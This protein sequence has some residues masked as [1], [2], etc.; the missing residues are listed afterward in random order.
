[1]E[2][3]CHKFGDIGDFLKILVN[4]NFN[5]KPEYQ[6]TLDFIKYV[7][8]K[9]GTELMAGPINEEDRKKIS[10]YFCEKTT[11]TEMLFCM[12]HF[13]RANSDEHEFRKREMHS[14]IMTFFK[15]SEKYRRILSPDF[16][17]KIQVY[18]NCQHSPADE[19]K[20]EQRINNLIQLKDMEFFISEEEVKAAWIKIKDAL[21]QEYTS[22]LTSLKDLPRHLNEHGIEEIEFTGEKFCFLHHTVVGEIF[23]TDIH[24]TLSAQGI[25]KKLHETWT[26]DPS[27]VLDPNEYETD[28]EHYNTWSTDLLTSNNVQA[29]YLDYRHDTDE[30]VNLIFTNVPAENIMG[31]NRQGDGRE[32]IDPIWDKKMMTPFEDYKAQEENKKMVNAWTGPGETVISKS[33]IIK[34]ESGEERVDNSVPFLKPA[35]VAICGSPNKRDISIAKAFGIP[36]VKIALDKYPLKLQGKKEQTLYEKTE[37]DYSVVTNYIQEREEEKRNEKD[38]TIKQEEQSEK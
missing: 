13:L 29:L 26:K 11:A 36:F 23:K 10:K 8:Q 31:N 33:K 20:V 22:N 21:R 28:G 3:I 4:L 17:K 2:N 27:R 18:A 1:M 6:Q 19:I 24:K 35:A 32:S 38:N 9:T 14:K 12:K 34:D 30:G 15:L 7:L 5:Y 25:G 37:Y 16:L